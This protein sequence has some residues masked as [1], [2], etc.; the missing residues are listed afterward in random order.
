MTNRHRRSAFTLVEL[1]VVI[2]IIG[3][4]VSL[5]LPA[6]NAAREAARRTQ[7]ANQLRQIGLATLMHENTHRFF[8][9]GG[10]GKDW[11]GEPDRGFGKD[12]PGSWAFSI[13][14]Y[15][16][17][18]ARYDLARNKPFNSVDHR[19]A[20][21]RLHQ[22]PMTGFHCPSRRPVSA[23]GHGWIRVINA[24]SLVLTTPNV[25]K[26]D[27]AVNGG[28]GTLSAGDNPPFR[29]PTSLSQAEDPNFEW[30]RVLDQPNPTNPFIVY[31]NGISFYRSEVK[32]R[33]IKDGMSKTYLVG[34]KHVAPDAYEDWAPSP[35]FQDWGENQSIWTGFEWDNT[36]LTHFA[37][38]GDRY[39]PSRDTPGRNGWFAFGSAHPGSFNAVLCDGAVA[40][41]S[42]DIDREAHRRLGNRLDGQTVSV[43][44][45]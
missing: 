11:T 23:K 39:E 29:V 16:E 20:M 32:I 2:A 44:D 40:N 17:E 30:T 19:N 33:Q 18:S 3:I 45:L 38:E 8:P 15:M 4:L 28:D 36:R 12:Q 6:V 9:S 1:L 34:E 27:Y 10:W 43:T 7:C 25:A 31:I 41:I 14:P 5:L 21:Q 24:P 35:D 26:S 22:E 37:G 42:Y 13:L